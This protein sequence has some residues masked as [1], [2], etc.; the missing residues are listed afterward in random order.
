MTILTV[1]QYVAPRIGLEVP[2]SFMASTTR[3]HVELQ[4]L[5][6]DTAEMIAKAH[7]WQKLSG[8]ATITGDGSTED[9]DLATDFDWMPDGNQL[10]SSSLSAPLTK[11]MTQ[12]EWLGLITQNTSLIV[13]SWIMYGDEI[14][15]RQALAS[16][17]TAKYFYQSNKYALS[18]STPQATFTADA[19]TFRLDE[20]LLKYGM[21]WRWKSDKGL[22]Y[23]EHMEDY[24]TLLAQ[25][26]ARDKGGTVLRVGHARHSSDMTY[27]YPK[28]LT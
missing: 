15:I 5:A 8:I 23:G 25:L 28:D 4:E 13:S 10:W 7:P 16:S 3:E 18:G 22:P 21:I 14:H 27:A 26:I 19:N 24:N 11:I 17:V 9:W 12:D 20:R 1:A 6:R 2:T